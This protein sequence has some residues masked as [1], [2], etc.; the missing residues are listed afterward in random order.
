M[1]RAM[2]YIAVVLAKCA[3]R[4]CTQ[5]FKYLTHGK[6]FHFPRAAGSSGHARC[7]ESS[8]YA[9]TVRVS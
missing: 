6:L 8:G 9:M 1:A 4:D 3:N 7:M 2:H 5:S